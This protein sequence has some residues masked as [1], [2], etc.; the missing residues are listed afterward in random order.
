MPVA[1]L[2]HGSPMNAIE[3]NQFTKGWRQIAENIPKPKAILSI[4]AHWYT[5]GTRITAED[6]PKTIYDFYGFP[7]ELYNIQYDSK[8]SPELAARVKDLFGNATFD[9]SWGYD[10]GTWSILSVMYPKADIPVIQLSI[11]ANADASDHFYLAEKLKPL[12]DE[13]VLI[14][15]SG[16]VVHNLG[17]VN[18][19]MHDGYDWAYVFDKYILE[20]VKTHAYEDIIDY[21]HF[22]KSAK[23]SVPTPEHFYPLLYVLGVSDNDD[24]VTVYNNYCVNGGLSMTSYVLGL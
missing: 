14:L 6:N 20:K 15:G 1:F 18:F 13:G 9:N 4:S 21:R 17:R 10:H 7:R 19:D 8:G 22:G 24:S 16:D 12:R 2:G 3:E 5:D 23:L 11:N